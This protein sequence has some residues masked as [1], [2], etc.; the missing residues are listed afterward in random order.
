MAGRVRAVRGDIT[1]LEVDAVVNAVNAALRP[2]GGVDGAIRRAAGWRMNAALMKIGGCPAGEAVATEGFALPA[3]WA[4]HTAG[5]VWEGGGRNEAELLAR[6]YR[7]SLARAAELG[8]RRVAFPAIS[9]GAYGFPP[10]KA[11]EIA[12]RETTA[13]LEGGADFDEILLVAFGEEDFAVLSAAA[14]SG[15]ADDEG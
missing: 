9:T 13:A 12:V 10:D 7:N 6:C 4:I 14:G 15:E 3:R 2:G 11:A 5:P 8:A 1:K